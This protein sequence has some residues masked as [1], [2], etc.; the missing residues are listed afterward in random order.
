MIKILHTADWHLDSPL[1]LGNESQARLLKNALA[2]IPAKIAAICKAQG[3]DLALLSGD[4]LDGAH[5]AGTLE[6]LE[7]ILDT[8]EVLSQYKFYFSQ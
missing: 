3:C 8:D 1:N 6:N 2:Q 7:E 4:L 5:S